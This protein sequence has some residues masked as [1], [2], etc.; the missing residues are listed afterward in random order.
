MHGYTLFIGGDSGYDA[1]FKIIG[2]RFK[3]FDLAFLECGQYGEDWPQIHM[4]PEETAKAAK[5]LN[6]ATLFP[7]HWSKFTLSN[8]PWNDPVKRLAIATQKEAQAFVSPMI[9]QPYILGE[10]FEQEEWWNFD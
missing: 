5:D 10:N 3:K 2:E 8:H 1:Q 9:G 6:A 4:M 7:V